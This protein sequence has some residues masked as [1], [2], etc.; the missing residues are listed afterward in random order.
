MYMYS[1]GS[2][3]PAE[4]FM[5]QVPPDH[6]ENQPLLKLQLFQH[7]GKVDIIQS[8]EV[9]LTLQALGQP[10]NLQDFFFFCHVC[11]TSA[12]ASENPLSASKGA[13]SFALRPGFMGG[14]RNQ[15]SSSLSCTGGPA[16]NRSR[17]R[18]SSGMDISPIIKH[19]RKRIKYRSR[20]SFR[21]VMSI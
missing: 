12:K 17:C 10:G 9:L 15:N 5:R 18:K 2:V 1:T 3:S 6:R 8:A 11:R 13:K 19:L 7:D 14:W 16:Q 20:F 4:S 21:P